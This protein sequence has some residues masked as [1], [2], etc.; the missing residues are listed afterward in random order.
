MVAIVA[1]GKLHLQIRLDLISVFERAGFS[2]NKE[3]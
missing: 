2:R 1:F 3:T